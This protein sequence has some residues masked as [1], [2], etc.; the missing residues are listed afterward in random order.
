MKEINDWLNEF[1][2]NH[3]NYTNKSI[4]IFS[5][6]LMFWSIVALLWSI[7]VPAILLNASLNW[8]YVGLMIALGYC[9]FLSTS[10]SIGMLAFCY[11]VLFTTEAVEEYFAVPIWQPATFTLAVSW[12]LQLIGHRIEKNKTAIKSSLAFILIGPLWLLSFPYRAIGIKIN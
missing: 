8:A 12:L 7:P 1:N 6:P 10:L 4:H 9:M 2:K 3:Q 5:I 11:I